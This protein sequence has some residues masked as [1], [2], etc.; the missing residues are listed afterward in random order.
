MLLFVV[1]F[2]LLL[3]QI[4]DAFYRLTDPKAQIRSYV[5]DVVRSESSRSRQKRER[6]TDAACCFSRVFDI[7][8]RESAEQVLLG[9]RKL[10]TCFPVYIGK[11]PLVPRPNDGDSSAVG[12]P[13]LFRAGHPVRVCGGRERVGC[14]SPVEWGQRLGL[15]K[16]DR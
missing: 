1:M 14:S 16:S 11:D 6:G 7:R 15:K 2:F 12:D 5:Y 9:A 4:Y 10:I 3:G 13:P 8:A